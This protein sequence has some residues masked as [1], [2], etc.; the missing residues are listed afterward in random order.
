MHIY[1]VHHTHMYFDGLFDDMT[2]YGRLFD[3]SS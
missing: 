3:V 2:M 1:I